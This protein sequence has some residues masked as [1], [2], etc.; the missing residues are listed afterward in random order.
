MEPIRVGVIGSGWGTNVLAPAFRA[1]SRYEFVAL[2]GGGAHTLEAAAKAG[3]AD[4][5]THWESFV[6]RP[7]L[8]MIAIATPVGLHYPMAMAA[9][10]AGKH[11]FCEK[12][13]ALSVQEAQ[14]LADAAEQKGVVN[15][16]GFAW[17]W[18]PE[19]LAFAQAVKG[20]ALGRPRFTHIAHDVPMWHPSGAAPAAWKFRAADGGGFL[21]AV[22]CHEIDFVRMLYGEPVAVSGNVTT[23]LRE[24]TLADGSRVPVDADDTCNLQLRFADDSLAVITGSALC[25]NGAG[26]QVQAFGDTGSVRYARGA[27]A[28]LWVT[29]D[30]GQQQDL[31][32]DQREPKGAEGKTAGAVRSTAL[33]LEDLV[34]RFDGAASPVP[35]LRDGM[36]IQ[37]LADALRQSS[38]EA[39]W[40][41]VSE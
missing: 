27:T 7:D 36:R 12:P 9:I 1:V 8:N 28:Q 23:L 2:C 33:M 17:R 24:R 31:P 25:L 16:T 29:R 41:P 30:N 34:P 39:R 14:A 3:I 13:L 32:G 11:V 40:V 21:N 37:Q 38:A 22:L 26:Q 6:R 10:E 35:T 20:G 15:V 5:S 18:Q 19:R 4:V